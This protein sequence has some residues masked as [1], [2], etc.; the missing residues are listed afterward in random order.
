M[1]VFSDVSLRDEV[2]TGKLGPFVNFA[3]I[4]SY[5]LLL[6]SSLSWE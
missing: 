4:A 1:C 6:A 3:S 5:I 2:G